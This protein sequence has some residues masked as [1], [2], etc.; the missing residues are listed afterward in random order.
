MAVAEKQLLNLYRGNDPVEVNHR[1]RISLE[2]TGIA[3]YCSNKST[4]AS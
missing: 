2:T 1:K 4:N 3:I